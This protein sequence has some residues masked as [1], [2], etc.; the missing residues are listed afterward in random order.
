MPTLNSFA[1]VPAMV[2]AL[3][4]TAV[5]AAAADLPVAQ[6]APAY[7]AAPAVWS[8][9]EQS[10]NQYRPYRSHRYRYR[11]GPS[12]GD[13]VTGLLIIGAIAAVAD[14]ATDNDNRRHREDRYPDYRDSDDRRDGGSRGIDGAVDK[15][16][17]AVERERRVESVDVAQRSAQGWRV[18]GRTPGGEGFSC[19]LSP[20]GQIG[21][22]DFRGNSD[23]GDDVRYPDQSY[24]TTDDGQ[25]M[26]QNDNQWDDDRYR[27][28]WDRVNGAGNASSAVADP[29]V[30]QGAQPA[31]PGGPLPGEEAWADDAGG[32]GASYAAGG[33]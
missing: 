28:E 11:R 27:A 26:A 6:T 30:A 21:S 5:P 32:S 12:V 17:D 20:D 15:C 31:Y 23:W 4:L 14:A 29:A 1:A 18:E 16:V 3:S 24:Q 10:W 8:P 22:I 33:I 19:T 2:A 9:D 7:S 25:V 13:V